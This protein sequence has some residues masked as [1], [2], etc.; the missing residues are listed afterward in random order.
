MWLKTFIFF[1][2]LFH[3][4]VLTKWR[5]LIMLLSFSRYP[6]RF[7]GIQ[8]RFFFLIYSFDKKNRPISPITLSSVFYF[9]NCSFRLNTKKHKKRKCGLLHS[10]H[11]VFVLKLMS[12]FCERKLHEWQRMRKKIPPKEHQ[13]STI[14]ATAYDTTV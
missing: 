13:G 9:N 4:W 1:L 8:I 14:A 2:F 3:L 12:I 10:S 6:Y 5:I 7:I 11:E